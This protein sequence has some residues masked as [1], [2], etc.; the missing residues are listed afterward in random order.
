[1]PMVLIDHDW[2]LVVEDDDGVRDTMTAALTD[3]GYQVAGAPSGQEALD[4]IARQRPCM[5]F[6]DL[7]MPGIDGWEVFRRLR[8]DVT[9]ADIPVCIMTAVPHKAPSGATSVLP[10]PVPLQSVLDLLSAYC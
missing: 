5:I 9:L 7:M 3:E 6:L 1:M 2:V 10:K 4:F 8:A